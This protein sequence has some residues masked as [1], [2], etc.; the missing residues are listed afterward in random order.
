MPAPSDTPVP[1]MN[2]DPASKLPALT[3]WT[4]KNIAGDNE[5]TLKNI[6][7][8]TITSC[9]PPPPDIGS[10]TV[11][12]ATN[13][14]SQTLDQTQ[15]RLTD[16]CAKYGIQQTGL[17]ANSR[18]RLR[19][20]GELETFA[21]NNPFAATVQA[22][23]IRKPKPNDIDYPNNKELQA[24]ITSDIWRNLTSSEKEAA[25]AAVNEELAK[26][27][28]QIDL[29]ARIEAPGLAG[30]SKASGCFCSRTGCP[31]DRLSTPINDK[32]VKASESDPI[33]LLQVRDPVDYATPQ[34]PAQTR[35]Q[36][37][38]LKAPRTLA[39]KIAKVNHTAT[40]SPWFGPRP[41]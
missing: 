12:E 6:L 35:K 18:L 32:T 21:V 11:Q 8:D 38:A 39:P 24:I 1:P 9:A 37:L 10:Q 4:K 30:A 7:I 13:S 25:V 26:R 36:R 28:L 3:Y 40:P 16:A 15:E 5:A 20:D 19:E 29:W 14:V 33:S 34:T 23:S 22:L 2:G 41:S 17:Q 31:H 27:R